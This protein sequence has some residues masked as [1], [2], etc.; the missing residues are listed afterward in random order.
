MTTARLAPGAGRWMLGGARGI[1]RPAYRAAAGLRRHLRRPP[2]S[3]WTGAS[4]RPPSTSPRLRGGRASQRASTA[5][6][7]LARDRV[8]ERCGGLGHLGEGVGDPG[9]IRAC[10]RPVER[11]DRVIE[12]LPHRRRPPP[13]GSGPQLVGRRRVLGARHGAP[14]QPGRIGV[15]PR[16]RLGRRGLRELVQPAGEVRRR[17]APSCGR[18]SPPPSPPPACRTARMTW[19]RWRSRSSLKLIGAWDRRSSAGSGQTG[20]GVGEA[21][22][23]H[24]PRSRRRS[25]PPALDPPAL[26]PL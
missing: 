20:S 17:A 16:D 6:L 19:A 26:L 24:R 12:A 5:A 7:V 9:G 8:G 13:A 11:A 14:V 21:R 22:P 4:V 23:A 15:L 1:A 18:A 10:D 2:A 3:S 25:A